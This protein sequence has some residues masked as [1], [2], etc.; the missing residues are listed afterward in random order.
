METPQ[1]RVVCA[2][3]KFQ[4]EHGEIV[5]ASPRHYDKTCVT[6]LKE[7]RS[8]AFVAEIDQGFLDQFGEFMTRKQAFLVAQEAGQI[9][10]TCGSEH[11]GRLYSENL[12]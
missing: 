10:R 12:Y 5:I 2:A 1:R 4:T 3:T 6:V 7:L 9:I 11:T 8:H